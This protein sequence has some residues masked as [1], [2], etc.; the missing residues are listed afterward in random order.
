VGGD[1]VTWND[2]LSK[3]PFYNKAQASP[4]INVLFA[5]LWDLI[6]CRI[7]KMSYL[8]PSQGRSLKD[9]FDDKIPAISGVDADDANAT[10]KHLVS[11]ELM[12][13]LKWLIYTAP[14]KDPFAQP[15]GNQHTQ[16]YFD[17]VATFAD[18]E[19][20]FRQRLHEALDIWYGRFPA[21]KKR[22]RSSLGDK[23][24]RAAGRVLED[25]EAGNPVPVGDGGGEGGVDD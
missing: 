10:E 1:D 24:P 6:L 2:D 15:R 7:T 5:A 12:A 11:P 4:V 20:V 16:F 3:P 25:P 9:I 17:W 18:K 19:K 21:T 22:S 13:Y 14:F 23:F 8:A